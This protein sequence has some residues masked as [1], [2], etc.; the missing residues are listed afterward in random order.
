MRAVHLDRKGRGRALRRCGRRATPTSSPTW[1]STCP[2]TSTPLLPA[3]R[4]A[5]LGPQ[6]PRHRDPASRP[7]AGRAGPEA[8]G[9]LA[10]L[11]LLLHVVLR[12]RFPDAQCGFKAGRAAARS[13]RCCR[14]SQDD[15]WFFD[16]ELLVLAE[17]NGLRIHEVPVD[18]VDD[19]DSRVDVVAHR[20]RRPE[21][22]VAG[23]APPP[24]ARRSASRRP[25][26][27]D[28]MAGQLAP[29]ATIGVV[30]TLLYVLGFNL[31]RSPLG[32]WPA[33][34]VALTA[35]MVLEHRGQPPLHLRLA[36]ADRT[37]A[38]TTSRPAPSTPS[39]SSCPSPPSAWSTSLVASPS[40]SGADTGAAAPPAPSPPSCASCSCGRGSSIPAGRRR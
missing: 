25:D 29:F 24:G 9:D 15:G 40:A 34:V 4:A 16:T 14:W 6:R 36:G 5:R 33:N 37:A 3:G 31:L 22:R 19:P 20:R 18:W 39:A 13:R 10:L 21:G 27:P 30:C 1:T 8:R 2:P 17:R 7:L 26:L 23:A 38:A 12:T 28:G 32:A 35:T 11:Q